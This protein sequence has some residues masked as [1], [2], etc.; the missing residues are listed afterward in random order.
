MYIYIYIYHC[1]IYSVVLFM[2]ILLFFYSIDGATKI[3][4]SKGSVRKLMK[5]I[6]MPSF[7]NYGRKF[8]VM[9]PER[10]FKY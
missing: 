4:Y 9:S 1:L 10:V 5:Y 3:C 7:R 6:L 2:V 8:S